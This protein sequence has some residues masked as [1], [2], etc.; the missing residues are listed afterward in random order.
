[1]LAW[2]H[3][4]TKP[5]TL[6]QLFGK[7]IAL[8]RQITGRVAQE[9]S[10]YSW[11]ALTYLKSFP[12]ACYENIS[13]SQISS[14]FSISTTFPTVH[15]CYTLHAVACRCSGSWRWGL[16]IFRLRPVYDVWALWPGVGLGRIAR[17]CQELKMGLGRSTRLHTDPH[18]STWFNGYNGWIT[19]RI[20]YE[21]K[22]MQLHSTCVN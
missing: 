4:P 12:S 16:S 22:V 15:S 19:S 13:F 17:W 7:V 2:H 18:G 11:A 8:T 6:I 3:R 10:W 14:H 5:R 1:M 21:S 20:S 9:H